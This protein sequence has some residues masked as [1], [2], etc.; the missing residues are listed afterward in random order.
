MKSRYKL[1][2][3]VAL[4]KDFPNDGLLKGQVGTIVEELS[5]NEFI[6]EFCDNEGK[7]YSLKVVKSNQIIPLY[8]YPQTIN[9]DS[10]HPSV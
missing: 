9:P 5:S 8:F 1:L 6:V 2:D 3:V 7:T 10:K 4:E